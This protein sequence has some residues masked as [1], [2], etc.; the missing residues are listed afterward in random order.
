M[1]EVKIR[2]V[3]EAQG[4]NTAYKLQKALNIAPSVA[5]RLFNGEF[6]Q[7][8]IETM[9]KLCTVLDVEAGELFVRVEKKKA[10]VRRRGKCQ[11]KSL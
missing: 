10:D 5:A 1:I 6:K 7:I 4:I 9:D 2:E 3:A 11:R 8:S